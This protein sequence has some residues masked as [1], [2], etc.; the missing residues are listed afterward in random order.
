MKATKLKKAA[1]VAGSLSFLAGAAL[2]QTAVSGAGGY[3][4]YDIEPGFNLIGLTLHNPVEISGT[5]VSATGTTVVTDTDLSG[6][7]ALTYIMEITSGTLD[8]TIQEITA[9]SGVNITTPEDLSADLTAGDTFQLRA[10]ATIGEVFG[11]GDDVVINKGTSITGDLVMIPNGSG[12]FDQYHHTADSIFGSGAW[13]AVPP[14][15]GGANRPI[16]YTDGVYVQN[17]G[18]SAYD[19]V[20]TGM[21]KTENTNIAVTESFNYFS[22]IYPVG[23]TLGTSGLADA[24]GFL[25]GT[26]TSGDLVFLPNNSGG[27][28]QYTHTA[29]SIFGAGAW[30]PVPPATGG[31]NTPLTSG[32]IL[33]RRAASPY[34]VDYTPPAFYDDL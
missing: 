19:I 6:L 20:L 5:V 29:D 23:S 3:T 27:F 13:T 14:A 12:G 8:G 22:A 2:A 1:L 15:T 4:T 34:N 24:P 17:R 30:T 33:Q 7:T 32:W 18:G 11:T 21:V 31:A 25:K 9:W 28:D 16:V 10:A 26:S